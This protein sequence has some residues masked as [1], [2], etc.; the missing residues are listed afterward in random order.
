MALDRTGGG[1]RSYLDYSDTEE[2]QEGQKIR[3]RRGAEG[4]ENAKILRRGGGKHAGASSRY[5]GRILG[6]GRGTGTKGA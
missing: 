3:Q 6:R 2:N 5:R 1:T 4:H